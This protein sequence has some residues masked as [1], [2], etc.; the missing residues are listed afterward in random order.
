MLMGALLAFQWPFSVY[1]GGLREGQRQVGLNGVKIVTATLSGAGA[2]FV[3]W[4]CRPGSP[5]FFTWQVAV[6]VLQVILIT[7]SVVLR[8]PRLS[9]DERSIR[10]SSDGLQSSPPA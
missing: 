10:R 3:L 4:A 9:S 5:A 1:Q 7:R 8:P 2:I 6:A